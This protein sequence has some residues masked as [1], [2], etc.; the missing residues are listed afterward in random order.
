M[1]IYI[2]N[3]FKTIKQYLMHKLSALIV[4]LKYKNK[5]ENVERRKEFCLNL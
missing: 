1:L 2:H 3:A 5:V 4:R